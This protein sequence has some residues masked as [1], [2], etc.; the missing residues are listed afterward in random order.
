MRCEKYMIEMTQDD[1]RYY[2]KNRKE[3]FI[4]DR[5]ISNSSMRL[6]TQPVSHSSNHDMKDQIGER[7]STF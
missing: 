3:V 2:K 1:I 4:V 7:Q 6:Q 5:I